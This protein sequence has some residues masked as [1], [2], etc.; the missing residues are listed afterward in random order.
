MGVGLPRRIPVPAAYAFGAFEELRARLTGQ[1]P[2]LT[3]G[4]VTIFAHDWP[5]EGAAAAGLLGYS[6]TPLS[7]GMAL[8]L[9]SVPQEPR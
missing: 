3:R 4:A 8:T 5:L 7:E 1:R 2:L 6:M 9:A